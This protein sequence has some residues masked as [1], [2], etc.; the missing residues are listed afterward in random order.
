MRFSVAFVAIVVVVVVFVVVVVA[1][2]PSRTLVICRLPY[3]ISAPSRV[4]V[5]P[6]EYKCQ[7]DMRPGICDIPELFG[8]AQ[9]FLSMLDAG[10]ALVA[11]LAFFPNERTDLGVQGIF[12]W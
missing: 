1:R 3:C 6:C 9:P 12:M 7:I 4:L 11:L 5:I 10:D 2:A 8:G